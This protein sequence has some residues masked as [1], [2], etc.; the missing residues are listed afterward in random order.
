VHPRVVSSLFQYAIL[1]KE[2]S[3]QDYTHSTTPIIVANPRTA[4]F[5]SL[6][7]YPLPK[8]SL[9]T[10]TNTNCQQSDHIKS[11]QQEA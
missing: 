5:V 7:S 6:F 9:S 8:H 4:N 2:K 11:A 10:V 3:L 1:S